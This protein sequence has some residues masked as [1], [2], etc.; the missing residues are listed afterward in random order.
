MQL[1]EQPNYETIQMV[2]FQKGFFSH[3]GAAGLAPALTLMGGFLQ[4]TQHKH[5]VLC[6]PN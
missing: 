4:L 2:I 6:G 3:T 5:T 1:Q